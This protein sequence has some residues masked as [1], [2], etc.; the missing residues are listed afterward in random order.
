M[1]L[2]LAPNVHLQSSMDNCSFKGHL[3]SE[4]HDTYTFHPEYLFLLPPRTEFVLSPI[5]S[6]N[7]SFL[8]PDSQVQPSFLS[9]LPFLCTSRPYKNPSI[10]IF[11]INLSSRHL[12]LFLMCLCFAPNYQAPWHCPLLT[13]LNVFSLASLRLICQNLFL[14][15]VYYLPLS[16]HFIN[17]GFY[18]SQLSIWYTVGS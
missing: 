3:C 16:R 13:Q 6:V 14:K 4:A 9:T 8:P 12:L 15:L 10:C 1:F 18:K 2:S 17:Y 7:Y 11:K 5:F